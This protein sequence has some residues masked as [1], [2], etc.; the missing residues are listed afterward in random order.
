MTQLPAQFQT[1]L[2][3]RKWRL[4]PH[5]DHLIATADM[6]SQ[7]LIAPTGAGKT[8]SGFLPTLIELADGNH[9]GVAK[10]FLYLYRLFQP[11]L[12]SMH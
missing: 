8:L 9:L 12:I 5:Q 6:Q 4:H 10:Q 3:R 2:S 1:W 7:L 11:R